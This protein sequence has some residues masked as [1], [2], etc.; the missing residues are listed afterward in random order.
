MLPIIGLHIVTHLKV[1][2]ECNKMFR[3]IEA[4]METSRAISVSANSRDWSMGITTGL[5]CSSIASCW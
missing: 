1:N 2:T 3:G 5:C 4:E